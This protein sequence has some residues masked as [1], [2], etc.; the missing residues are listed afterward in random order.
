MSN[1]E[2]T[3]SE[4]PKVWPMWVRIALLPLWIVGWFF[5]GLKWLFE[6]FVDI[7]EAVLPPPEH[8]SSAMEAKSEP[9]QKT[10]PAPWSVPNKPD[11]SW[12]RPLPS[13]AAVQAVQKPGFR[14]ALRIVM[15]FVMAYVISLALAAHGLNVEEATG[16]DSASASFNAGIALFLVTTAVACLMALVWMIRKYK[17]LHREDKRTVQYGILGFIVGSIFWSHFGGSSHHGS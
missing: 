17:G 9:L 15:F 6:W 16:Q 2:L 5:V 12:D 8:D 14:R 3:E 1:L 7:I 11:A 4:S 13:E 10:S